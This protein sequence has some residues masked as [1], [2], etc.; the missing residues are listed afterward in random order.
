MVHSGEGR[1]AAAA[2][3]F[4]GQTRRLKT[5]KKI[6]RRGKK[7]AEM[8]KAVVHTV[9]MHKHTVELGRTFST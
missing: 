8:C 2:V 7:T 3:C 9:N 4:P 6:K 5:Q 1:N